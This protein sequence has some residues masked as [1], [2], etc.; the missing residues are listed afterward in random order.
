M[1]L[2]SRD[3]EIELGDSELMPFAK[4]SMVYVKKLRDQCLDADIP[5]MIGRC[6]G[7]G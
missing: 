4:G 1:T 2:D 3:A 6:E 5:V 7:K